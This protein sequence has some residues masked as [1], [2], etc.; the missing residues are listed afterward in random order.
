MWNTKP[1]RGKPFTQHFS[2]SIRFFLCLMFLPCL[3]KGNDS[4]LWQQLSSIQQKQWRRLLHYSGNKSAV[5]TPDFF[6]AADGALNP[7][8]ELN[9]SIR[10]LDTQP[11]TV[12]EKVSFQCRYPLRTRFLAETLNKHWPTQNCPL[13]QFWRD[14]LAT[15]E[16]DLVFASSFLGNP[17]SSFGHTLLKFVRRGPQGK[18]RHDLLS[19]GVSYGANVTSN[20][21]LSYMF[22]GTFG[23]FYGVFT[24]APYADK[25]REYNFIDN[26][27]LW[28]FELDL[29]PEQIKQV[30]D[31]LWELRDARMRYYFFDRNCSYQ[32]LTFLEAIDPSLDISKSF[33]LWVIPLDTVRALHRAGK[34]K[35]FNLRLAREKVITNKLQQLT[36]AEKKSVLIAQESLHLSGNETSAALDTLIDVN[37]LQINNKPNDKSI[38]E[39]QNQVLLARQN[40]PTSEEMS[41]ILKPEEGPHQKSLAQVVFVGGAFYNDKST[42]AFGGRVVGKNWLESQLGMDP[43]AELV[44]ADFRLRIAQQILA[45]SKLDLVRASSL[46]PTRYLFPHTAWRLHLGG[47]EQSTFTCERCFTG[48]LSG[49]VGKTWQLTDS[50]SFLLL[51]GAKGELDTNHLTQYDVGAYSSAGFIYELT[52]QLALTLEGGPAYMLNR[53]YGWEVRSRLHLQISSSWILTGTSQYQNY[54]Q[55]DLHLTQLELGYRF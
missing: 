43:Q 5:I 12:D 39:F 7:A 44:A 50:I 17:A 35:S 41:N 6:V 11:P 53:F 33:N 20:N 26:R 14:K 29:T 37:I 24:I 4:D 51:L 22:N 54:L 40:Q 21:A 45:L 15:V 34:V 13:L 47:E 1:M 32:I 55:R 52:E 10:L 27:D 2:R 19:Y 36:A 42:P 25:L 9:E 48:I 30:I 16:V 3:A 23:Y 8:A 38:Q 28:N 46:A 49:E 31:H 18:P